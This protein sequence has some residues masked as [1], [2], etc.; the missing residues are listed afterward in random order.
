MMEIKLAKKFD[1][2][3]PKDISGEKFH[4]FV[5]SLPS[6]GM[7]DTRG[8]NSLINKTEQLEN[9][10]HLNNPKTERQALEEKS[11]ISEHKVASDRPSTGSEGKA[12]IFVFEK[13]GL[14]FGIPVSSVNE[15]TNDFGPVSPLDGF[16]RSCIGT[17][18]YRGKLLPLFESDKAYLKTNKSQTKTDDHKSGKNT[19]IT[20][21]YNNIMFALTMDSH[22]GIVSIDFQDNEYFNDVKTDEITDGFLEDIVWYKDE[23]LYIF[24]PLKLSKIVARELKGQVVEASSA[25][26]NSRLETDQ[27]SD[28][29]VVKIK[30]SQIA[31]ELTKVREVIEGFEVTAL[32]QVSD[33][34]RGLI[35]LRGQVLACIDLSNYLGNNLMVI[36]ERNKFIVLND[37]DSDFALCVDEIIG[38]RSL[39]KN[40]FQES[41]SVFPSNISE[42]F[43]SFLN[44]NEDLLLVMKPEVLINSEDVKRYKK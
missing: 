8:D 12:D 36:D 37:K 34:I 41:H 15:I 22:I 6:T 44:K 14:R 20:M 31:I 30:E 7:M 26:K 16:I 11:S 1:K 23:N 13:N 25:K 24:S 35:N 38:I 40:E 3:S 17:F 21:S 27:K 18:E 42:N 4:K 28:H 43:P 32:Y 19:I 33:F 9:T 10:E 5:D 39:D 2:I 29:L